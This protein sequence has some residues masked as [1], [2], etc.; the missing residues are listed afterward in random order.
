[1]R[2][3]L[4]ARDRQK[5][6]RSN[7]AGRSRCLRAGVPLAYGKRRSLDGNVR[8]PLPMPQARLHEHN[9]VSCQADARW[10]RNSLHP[11]GVE[12][13]DLRGWVVRRICRRRGQPE[14]QAKRRRNAYRHPG[15]EWRL[16]ASEAVSGRWTLHVPGGSRRPEVRH[17]EQVRQPGGGIH[18][19]EPDEPGAPTC[20]HD[21]PLA[22]HRPPLVGRKGDPQSARWGFL[23]SRRFDG[24][25]SPPADDRPRDDDGDLYRRGIRLSQFQTLPR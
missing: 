18:H 13:W 8:S 7:G 4:A 11:S 25:A 9:L 10:R 15:P 1:M 3:L 24:N 22:V 17:D 20:R 19:G 16:R 6:A 12:S 5:T 14:R 2:C 23:L 21:S